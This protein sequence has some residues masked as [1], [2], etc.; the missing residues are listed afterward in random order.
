MAKEYYSDYNNATKKGVIQE[1]YGNILPQG[2]DVPKSKIKPPKRFNETDVKILE[3]TAGIELDEIAFRL[4]IKMNAISKEL[5]M[6]EEEI[7]LVCIINPKDKEFKLRELLAKQAECEQM[8]LIVK[9]KYNSLG[10]FYK[11]SNAIAEKIEK[12]QN[13]FKKRKSDFSK[14][15]IGAF[16]FGIVPFFKSKFYLNNTMDKLDTI[17]KKAEEIVN[18]KQIPYGESEETNKELIEFFKTS[19][20]LESRLQN[21]FAAEAYKNQQ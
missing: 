12:M 8:L 7:R 5:Q 16:L 17:Y 9:E 2:I 1:K 20:V 11:I 3:D 19:S 21:F 4:E 15:R 6:I 13:F 14:T 18:L 10:D